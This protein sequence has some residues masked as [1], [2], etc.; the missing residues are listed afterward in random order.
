[1]HPRND[2]MERVREDLL[3][4]ANARNDIPV[5]N[6]QQ[7]ASYSF[8]MGASVEG[9]RSPP[10][11]RPSPRQS[12]KSNPS[13]NGVSER[14][15]LPPPRYPASRPNFA[16]STRP[17]PKPGITYTSSERSTQ[18]TNNSSTW[19]NSAHSGAGAPRFQPPFAMDKPGL[20]SNPRRPGRQPHARVPPASRPVYERDV[21]VR[22]VRLVEPVANRKLNTLGRDVEM[23]DIKHNR[24][25][26]AARHGNRKILSCISWPRSRKVRTALLQSIVSFVFFIGLLGVCELYRPNLS[27]SLC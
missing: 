21:P 7:Y 3:R 18:S 15:R 8:A 5:L 11:S 25:G 24:G 16:V 1:M 10:Q 19:S 17:A 6:Q 27:L 14:T 22:Q 23:G 20:P 26:R 12:P 4:R 2:Q 13:D 9:S